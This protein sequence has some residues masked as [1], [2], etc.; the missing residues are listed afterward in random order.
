MTLLHPPLRS[1]TREAKKITH[2][3]SNSNRSLGTLLLESN[4]TVDLGVAL[5]NSDSL[6][7]GV[8]S[9]DCRLSTSIQNTLLLLPFIRNSQ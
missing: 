4:H 2:I 9:V 1:T 5:E 3:T 6:E 8:M 7:G